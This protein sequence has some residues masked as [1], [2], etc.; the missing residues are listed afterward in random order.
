MFKTYKKQLQDNF[1]KLVEKSPHL[2]VV[3]VDKEDLWTWY[4]MSFSSDPAKMQEYNCNCCKSFVRNY[5]N[6]VGI[7]DNE[8]VT[9]WNFEAFEEFETVNKRMNKL[10]SSAKIRDIFKCSEVGMGTDKNTQLKPDMESIT[11]QHLY[12]ITPP[13]ALNKRGEESN[14]AIKGEARDNKNV[15]KRSLEELTL[16]SIETVLELIAQNSLYRGEEFKGMLTEFL[17]VKKEYIKLGENPRNSAH[18]LDN[19]CWINSMKGGVVNKIRNT[20]IGSLLIDLSEGK[21]LDK[22]VGSFEAKVAPTNYKRPTALVTKRMVEEAE[23]TI[24]KLGYGESLGR[25]FATTEDVKVTNLLYVNRD[26]EKKLGVFEEMKEDLAINPKSLKKVEEIG[27]DAFMTDVLPTVK[28]IELLLEKSHLGNFV[29][30]ITAKEKDAP[31]LF[32][33]NNPF[34]WCYT[35][36]ITDSIKERVKEAGGRVEGELRAS[37]SWT[38]S[39]DL[40][41]HII[42][43]KGNRIYFGN[44]V[45]AFTGG[46]LDVD[47]NAHSITPKPVE[48]IIYPYK[49]RMYEGEYTVTVHQFRK[50]QVENQ[51]FTLEI[52]CQG[53][54]F[55]F[56]QAKH[57]REKGEWTIQFNYSK[58][59][60]IT[61]SGDVKSST[62]S[63]EKWGIS[64]NKFHKVSM[65]M[66]SP[67]FWEGTIGNRHIFFI[68]E[69]AHNDEVGVRGFFNEFLKPELEKSKRVFEVLGGKLK[70]EHADKQLSGVGFSSTQ[71]NSVICKVRGKFERL[72]KINF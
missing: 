12:L 47:M 55:T 57:P 59:N 10:V 20:A 19:Y 7:V 70:V 37:L 9:M 71:R 67:N 52:E 15:F 62:S 40:D 29:S 2:F 28:G 4:I 68:L 66:N 25:R 17:K 72:L 18:T 36:G 21:E 24:N 50:R 53:E 58:K 49:E 56:E 1:K 44:K 22:A 31:I 38:N 43:P 45:S 65:I 35:N 14:E 46:N 42:E 11:W 26:A 34:S 51:G 39:D 3:D 33:W 30:L 23:E 61:I 69:G 27:I 13:N 6:V 8:I 5:G 48:N 16:D 64:T 32:K 60:G 41:L 54:V 63:I